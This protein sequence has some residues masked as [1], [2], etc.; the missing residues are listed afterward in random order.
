MSLSVLQ[1]HVDEMAHDLVKELQRGQGSVGAGLDHSK[2]PGGS[3]PSSQEGYRACLP[4]G[5]PRGEDRGTESEGLGNPPDLAPRAMKNEGNGWPW[6]SGLCA[7]YVLFKRD[8]EKYYGEQTRPMPQAELVQRFRENCMG[9]KTAKPLE[10]ASSMTE[11]W[12]MLD[13]FY[14]VTKGLMVEFQGLAAIKK[15]QFERQ[16]DHYFLIQYSISA[17]DEARQGHLLLVFANIEEMLQALPQREKT[18]WW[19]AWGHMGSRDLGST[20]SAFVEERLDWSLAQMTGT[21]ASGAKPT[22]T[23]T[24][25]HKQ[26]DGAGYSKRVKRGDGH[27]VGV[28]SPRTVRSPAERNVARPGGHAG[29]KDAPATV[30]FGD[31]PAGRWPTA[32]LRGVTDR[33][34]GSRP[35]TPRFPGYRAYADDAIFRPGGAN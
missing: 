4:G 5:I 8:W 27:E 20:F 34:T 12:T 21:G 32:A 28:R 16:Y 14:Y 33:F 31:K 15:R 29:R 10:K 18:L 7:D 30:N 24:K 1:A 2:G 35:E 6:F 26:D 17:A 3:D 11:A 25:N 9:E 13:D 23:P 19:D 22:L